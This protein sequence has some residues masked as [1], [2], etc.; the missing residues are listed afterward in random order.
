MIMNAKEVVL[1]TYASFIFSKKKKD[2]KKWR[3][4]I[5]FDL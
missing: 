4:F 1:C 5:E 2:N 3:F